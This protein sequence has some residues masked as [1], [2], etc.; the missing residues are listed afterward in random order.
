LASEE[1]ERASVLVS[2]LSPNYLGDPHCR[3]ELGQFLQKEQRLGRSDLVIPIHYIDTAFSTDALLIEAWSYHESFDWRKLRFEPFTA[4]PVKEAMSRLATDIRDRLPFPAS[5][6]TRIKSLSLKDFRCFKSLK[7]D[8]SAPST[9]SGNWTCIAGIN[10]AGKS[11]ILQAIGLALLGERARDLFSGR[12]SRMRRVGMQNSDATEVRISLTDLSPDIP[13]GEL[14][15]RIYENGRL[16]APNESVSANTTVLAYGATRNLA[17]ER[18]NASKELISREVQRMISLFSPLAQLPAAQGLISGARKDPDPLPLFSKLVAEVFGRELMVYGTL[19]TVHFAVHN[20]ERVDALDLPDG[21][22][23]AAAWL[24][25]LCAA[26]CEMHPDEAGAASPRDIDAIVLID[27]IDLHLHPSLQRELVPRLRKALPRVQWI[28][29]THSPLVLANFDANE[30]V[31]LDRDQDGNVRHIDRQILAFTTDEIYEW[32]MGTRPTGAAIEEEQDRGRLAEL[33]RTSPEVGTE[34]A[35]RQV[36][37]FRAI[38]KTI[39]RR[40]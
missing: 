4:Q 39:K 2:I 21:F 36:E 19:E 32:L 9:L 34:T 11:S 27:E 5:K 6:S 12:L 28:V 16:R 29:T 1:I 14:S 35:R 24:A 20:K 17:I 31:A 7:L 40:S 22:R 13:A 33:M 10:G 18:E 3:G 38:L 15:L 8:F 25:D 37:E 30:I 26:W 23:S